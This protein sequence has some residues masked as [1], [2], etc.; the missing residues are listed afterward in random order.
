MNA[1]LTVTN[2]AEYGPLAMQVVLDCR[3]GTTTIA[4]NDTTQLPEDGL[5]R[6]ALLK[7]ILS[8]PH[9]SHISLLVAKYAGFGDN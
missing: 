9:C 8:E 6:I 2:L 1:T 5:T 3:C 7:H 4:T